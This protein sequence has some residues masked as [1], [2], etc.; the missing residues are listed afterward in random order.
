[1]VITEA[2]ASTVSVAGYDSSTTTYHTRNVDGVRVFYREAG[3]RDAPVVV[4]LH[5]YPSSSRMWDSLIPFLAG[6][7]HVIA[8]DYPGFG[9][10]DR[11]SPKDYH[12]TFDNLA[13]TTLALLDDLNLTRYTLFMQDYGGPVG[14]RMALT[15]PDQ[16]QAI[17]VQN[18]N[19]YPEGL[20]AKWAN[21]AKYWEDP[22]G[23]QEQIDAFVGYDGTKKRHLGDSP[24]PER[25]NPDAWEDE[26]VAISRP[27]QREVQAALLYDYRTNVASYP[28]WQAWMRERR[29]P[30]L[31]MW[32]RYDPSF[33]TP[34]G[35]AYKR[36]QPDAEI[37][38]LDAGHFAL[39]EKTEE[40]ATL[41]S[42]FLDK[43]NSK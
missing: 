12:Y 3:P 32:G 29:L 11:P 27:G 18:A 22:K 8:P 2:T 25:Y 23:H 40:I 38:V 13:K 30:T 7:Y 5:G 42:N 28:R 17:I 4:L 41:T 39:D 19:A 20:G 37:H 21:I 1:M 33:I 14:F 43:V 24:N 31:V 35:T 36:D 6:R 9:Q 26:F 10:S 15:K 16:V 34:G